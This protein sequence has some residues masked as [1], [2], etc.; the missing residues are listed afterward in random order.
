MC[1]CLCVSAHDCVCDS[2]IL[3]SSRPKRLTPFLLSLDAFF[4]FALVCDSSFA[5]LQQ[6]DDEKEG[7]EEEKRSRAT[8]VA[9]GVVDLY[10][11]F[12][13]NLRNE[14]IAT[15]KANRKFVFCLHSFSFLASIS[16]KK[17]ILSQ[18]PSSPPFPIIH[19]LFLSLS[20]FHFQTPRN[21]EGRTD[22]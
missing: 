20:V 2:R 1:V 22:A 7:E 10:G 8:G 14:W 6:S 15:V 13:E 16:L 11:V 4:C 3:L 17:P 9:E 21:T 12:T 19:P 5:S 18:S